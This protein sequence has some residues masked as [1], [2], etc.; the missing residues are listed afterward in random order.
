[1]LLL[2]SIALFLSAAIAQTTPI[3]PQY[4]ES[5]GSGMYF[6]DSVNMRGTTA[7]YTVTYDLDIGKEFASVQ[8][9]DTNYKVDMY[10]DFNG[11]TSY[12][13]TTVDGS[14]VSCQ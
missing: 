14:V 1:M 11:A 2:T 6:F 4:A 10:L 8:M 5:A 13:V 9:I 3:L 7:T 12:M